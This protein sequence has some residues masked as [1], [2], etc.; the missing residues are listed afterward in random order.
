MA[1]LRE[2]IGD[3][4]FDEAFADAIGDIEAV[5]QREKFCETVA[6][7]MTSVAGWIAIDSWL[8][9]GDVRPAGKTTQDRASADNQRLDAFRGTALLFQIAADLGASAVVLLQKERRYASF[10]LVRQLI[11][12]EYLLTVFNNDFLE[13]G[14]W[15]RAS[16]D[17][18]RSQFMPKQTRK[19][20]GFDDHE[21]WK[22]CDRGGHPNPLG[23]YLL[24]YNMTKDRE[25][26][27]ALVTGECWTDLAHHLRR[28]WGAE[29]RLLV[30]HHARF[31]TVRK[32][33]ITAVK[34]AYDDW[35]TVDVLADADMLSKFM[36]LSAQLRESPTP[37]S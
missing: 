19:V 36:D 35:C 5:K 15:L 7:M 25:R 20:G 14:R 32:R 34:K 1:A 21:Y 27:E 4:D 16:P 12:S 37:E 29:V 13:A 8:G 28:A 10:A 22:H 17:E 23:W 24:P 33:E 18:I 31:G 26:R 30:A 6:E 2:L 11:E 3:G 9:V